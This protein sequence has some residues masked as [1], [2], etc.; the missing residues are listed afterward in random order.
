VPGVVIPPSEMFAGDMRD[1][2]KKVVGLEVA[3]WE[4]EERFP[5]E[6]MSGCPETSAILSIFENVIVWSGCM[7]L[8]KRATVAAVGQRDVGETKRKKKGWHS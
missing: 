1:P 3:F 2:S 7:G 6:P 4:K 5:I 8:K